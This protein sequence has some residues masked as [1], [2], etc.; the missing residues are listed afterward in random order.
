[1]DPELGRIAA[2]D[3]LP[4]LLPGA[5]FVILT[6]PLTGH[7]KGLFSAAEFAL[8]RPGSWLIN[9]GRGA[10]VDEQALIHGAAAPRP[11]DLGP[12]G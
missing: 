7:T 9:L 6:L 10:L 4:G 3:E 5:N 12:P 2:L 11:A 8:M 1:M